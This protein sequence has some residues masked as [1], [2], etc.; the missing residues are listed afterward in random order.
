MATSDDRRPNSH[1]E[2]YSTV[3]WPRTN[4]THWGRVM[5]IYVSKLTIIGSDNGSSPGRRQAI[6]WTN[7]GILLIG[8]LW[9]NF[10]EILSKIYTFFIQENA[11]E[12]VVC[13]MAAISSGPQ[14]VK[15]IY[16][17]AVYKDAAQGTLFYLIISLYVTR[18]SEELTE[19]YYSVQRDVFP[20][21]I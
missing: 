17:W 2:L 21:V 11:F 5:H 6:I 20:L 12:N 19:I 7:A 14:C 8:T 18:T 10:S 9:T 13:E 3:Q 15:S 4:L 1:K 16:L